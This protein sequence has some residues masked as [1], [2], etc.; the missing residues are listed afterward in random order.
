LIS[1][2]ESTYS[3]RK[4]YEGGGIMG[5]FSSFSKKALPEELTSI[6]LKPTPLGTK[7]FPLY[8]TAVRNKDLKN[9]DPM[10]WMKHTK[11]S[12]RTKLLGYLKDGLYKIIEMKVNKVG[13]FYKVQPENQKSEDGLWV[14]KNDIMESKTK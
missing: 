5:L 1:R 6:R 8:A 12:E 13:T 9:K 4:D 10:K 3:N 7:A 2:E 11:E 14:E